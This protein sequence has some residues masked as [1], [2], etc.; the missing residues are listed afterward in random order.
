MIGAGLTAVEFA[1]L[2]FDAP[3]AA[4]RESRVRLARLSRRE[5]QVMERVALGES[6][7]AIG[8]E[9]GISPRT[10]EVHRSSGLGKIGARNSF[11][12]TRIWVEAR[13]VGC[14]AP[15]QV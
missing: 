1:E 5:R 10:V 4:A 2:D 6:N 14:I 15:A 7:K 11:E 8:A 13:Y 12:A 9:L 3:D